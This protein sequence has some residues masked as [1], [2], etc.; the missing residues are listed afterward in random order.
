MALSVA[1]QAYTL[2]S[3][4]TILINAVIGQVSTS[5]YAGYLWI[6]HCL[7]IL[8]VISLALTVTSPKKF[9]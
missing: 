4:F 5:Q 1:S 8:T 2:A 3:L 6:F 7:A 9:T